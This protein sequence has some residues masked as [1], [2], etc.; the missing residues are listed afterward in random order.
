MLKRHKTFKLMHMKD[1]KEKKKGK[2]MTEHKI[3]IGTG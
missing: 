3:I 1:E 2:K